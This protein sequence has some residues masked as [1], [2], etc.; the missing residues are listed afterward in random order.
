MANKLYP[1]FDIPSL[2]PASIDAENTYK[3]TP[4]FDFA[5]GDFVR[6]GANRVVM[7]DG[8]EAYKMWVLKTLKTQAGT[9]LSYTGIG[10]DREGALAEVSREAEESA[11]ER[12]ITDALLRN[13]CTERVYNFEF[14]WSV[15]GLCVGFY[16]KP[17]TWTAFDV[18]MNV[19][20]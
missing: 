7:A 3:P 16:V 4:L 19:I 17:K 5:S 15:D 10:I 14:S 6:D 8:Y 11:L 2:R 1:T 20:K 9:C 13:P 12:T 18:A